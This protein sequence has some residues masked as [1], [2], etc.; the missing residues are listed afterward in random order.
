MFNKIVDLGNLRQAYLS[1]V[2]QM[3]SDGRSSRYAGWDS[4]KLADLEINSSTIIEEIRAE[5]ISLTPLSPAILVSIPKKNKPNKFREIYIYNLKDRIKAQA[6][7]QIV[8]PYF[9]N[10]LSP[11]LFSYRVSHP[12]YFA[13][14]S[15]VR[16]YHRYLNRDYIVV[17]DMA[18]YSSHIKADILLNKLR[19]MG[20]DEQM[21][22]LLSLFINNKEIRNGIISQPEEGLITGTPLIGL[23][24]NLYLDDF[25]KY[26]GKTADF[27]RRVGDDLII[28]DKDKDKLKMIYDLLLKEVIDLNL[29][30]HSYK[31]KIISASEPFEY[32]GYHFNNGLVSFTEGFLKGTL[33][34]WRNRFNYYDGRT[35]SKKNKFLILAFNRRK[36][37]LLLEFYELAKQ[38]K[39][40][41]DLNQVKIFSENFFH[42]LTIYFFQ[43][44]TPRNR[45]LLS[46]K[47]K[48]LK[49]VS[50]YKVFLSTIYDYPKSKKPTGFFK[51]FKKK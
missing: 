45:R 13:A 51:R 41:N 9:D 39:L 37:S 38:K 4:L 46:I 28:F 8:E 2:E 25:D 33:R 34:R 3:E 21:I 40:L 14:R 18:D 19:K 48:R 23:F 42:I 31:T 6:I 12:S 1:L 36:N 11:W 32:L 20:F 17:A 7:Y 24:N 15:A 30:I 29:H 50:F 27:Y 5:L 44:Y 26:C 49:L 43:K 35:I 10:Y 16:H 22:K 47:L